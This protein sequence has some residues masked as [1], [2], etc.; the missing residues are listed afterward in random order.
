MRGNFRK[1][2]F[3][4]TICTL[5][6]Y[7]LLS[8]NAVFAYDIPVLESIS[9]EN[10]EIEGGFS[11]DKYEYIITL[12]DNSVTP[13]LEDYEINGDAQLFI[14]YKTDEV[15]HQTGMV[16]ELKYP[17]GS[18]I[19]TFNYGNAAPV[20]ES[21]D[22]TLSD[23]YCPD[24]QLVPAINSDDTTYKLFIP[25]DM[26]EL[27][28]TPVPSD[29]NAYSPTL[30]LRLNKTQEPVLSVMCTATDGS[31]REYRLKVKRADMTLE[32]VRHLSAQGQE[33]SLSEGTRLYEQPY[34]I[35]TICAVFGGIVIL[36]IM[37]KLTRR[38]TAKAYD[39]NEK[40]FYKSEN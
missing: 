18:T 25:S 8:G 36:F 35:V 30:E 21:S 37:L 2:V 39:E 33:I 38:I 22:N 3:G 26:T 7:L 32:Q 31:Q 17:N 20:S 15:K 27:V 1:T 9:I 11:P 13:T 19:Y 12:E 14:S 24:C 10:A 28:I 5:A 23:L 4:I 6:F 16:A 34:F 40:P 29:P